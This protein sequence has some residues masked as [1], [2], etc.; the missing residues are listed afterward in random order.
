M[1]QLK[2][3]KEHVKKIIYG[4]LCSINFMHQ[5]GLM[6]RDIK[7]ANIL[8]DLDLNVK[9]CD[10][11]LARSVPKEPKEISDTICS[12]LPEHRPILLEETKPSRCQVK[13][14]LSKHVVTRCYRPPEI[15][16]LEKIY[17]GAVDVWAAGCVL[18]E[19][20]AALNVTD[21]TGADNLFRGD[22]CFPLSPELENS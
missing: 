20:L 12:M 21:L 18:F 17:F 8:L 19:L 6:H 3:S 16:L 4:I 14:K 2:L 11:G 10:Y 5:A 15:I 22:S 9:I 13:R 1:K 7:P